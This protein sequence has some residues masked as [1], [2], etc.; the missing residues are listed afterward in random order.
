MLGVR[1]CI[2]GESSASAGRG[3]GVPMFRLAMP[4]QRNSTNKGRLRFPDNGSP[5]DSERSEGA[6]CAQAHQS[7]QEAKRRYMDMFM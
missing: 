7:K 4:Y 6:V 1:K 3:R 2:W 5:F